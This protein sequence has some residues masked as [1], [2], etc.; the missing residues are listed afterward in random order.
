MPLL[1]SKGKIRY[2]F[3]V[4]IVPQL[5]ANSIIAGAT[6][7]L[8]AL[9]FNLIY[10]T[11]KFFN[12]AHGVVAAAGAYA[13]FALIS[14]YALPIGIWPAGI[15]GVVAAGTVGWGLNALVYA[16]LRARKASPMVL[17]V[18]S[19][20]AFTVIQ[21]GLAMLFTSQFQ[22]LSRGGGSGAFEVWGAII[23]HTQALIILA[24]ILIAVGL[25]LMM[26]RTLFGKAVAAIQDDEEV[27]RIVGIDTDAIIGKIF[28]IGS[29]IAGIAGILI[30]LD[31]GIEPTMGMNLLLKG[32]IA[33]IVGGV[34]SIM[35]GFFGAFIL[36]FAENFG[37]WKISGE[38]K[39]AIA[40]ALLIIFLIFRPQGI[41][42]K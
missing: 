2:I 38:W 11:T 31:T 5:T 23:T 25:V 7:A 36:G 28:F 15:L 13:V 21:A 17:M 40:F 34:G 6:Y 22:S 24:S 14:V 39:D 26:R 20:G 8:I 4:D 27:A 10:G 32:T 33:S 18:A 35:G 1:D 37:I 42:R 9:G 41:F 16:P 19:L 12:L 3:G 29:G 30:G